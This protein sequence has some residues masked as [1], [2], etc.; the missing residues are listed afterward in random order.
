MDDRYQPAAT[1]ERMPDGVP[2][3]VVAYAREGRRIEAI[4]RYRGLTR[5]SLLECWDVVEAIRSGSA[6]GT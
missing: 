1:F 3:E 2:V 5:S 6:S 4:A